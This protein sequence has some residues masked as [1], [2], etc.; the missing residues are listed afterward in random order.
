MCG[1]NAWFHG[2]IGKLSE[3]AGLRVTISASSGSGPD[4]MAL[5]RAQKLMR[6]LLKEHRS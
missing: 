2:E 5:K 1:H 4:E 3:N 6:W